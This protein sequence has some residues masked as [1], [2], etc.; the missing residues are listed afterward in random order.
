MGVRS[1]CKVRAFVSEAP[2]GLIAMLFTDL[3]GSTRLAA[4]LGDAWAGVLD[5]HHE[6][7]GDAIRTH[8]GWVEL[9]AGDGFFATFADVRSAALAGVSAQRELAAREW[10]A[11]VGELRVRMGLHV[12]E[13]ERRAHGCVGLEVHRASRV[14]AAAH[15]GQLLM[16][17]A[18]ADLV[19]DVVP[20]QPLGAHRLKDFPAPIALFSAV[21]DGRGAAA[22][23]PPRTLDVRPGRVPAAPARL[24][25]READLAR[26]RAALLNEGE[27][28]ITLLGR[29]G[30]GKTSLA[31]IAAN[32]LLDD[33]EGGV[34]WIDATQAG[35]VAGVCAAIARE[36]RVTSQEAGANSLIA[37]LASREPML[38]VL[39][40]VER[41]DGA[42]QLLDRLVEEIPDLA[43]LA[44]SQLPLRCRYERR[45]QLDCLDIS[46]AMALLHRTAER[47]DIPLADDD[48]A[49]IELVTLLDGL[50]LAIELA[51][52]RLRLFAPA[53]LLRRLHESPGILQDRTRPDRHRSLTAALDWTLALLDDDARALFERLGAFAGPVE[54][55]EIEAVAGGTGTDAIAGLEALLEPAL[56][57][58]IETGD[59][60]VRFGF[61]EVVRQEASRRLDAGGGDTWRRAHAERQ[62]DVVWPLRVYEIVDSPLVETGKRAAPETM[63]AL[64]WAWDHDRRLAREIALGRYPLAVHSGALQEARGLIDRLASD[65]GED[66]GVVDLLRVHRLSRRGDPAGDDDTVDG[67]VTLFDE[68]GDPHARFLCAFNLSITL[69]RD[70]RYDD[71]LTWNDSAS[72]EVKRFGA[73]AAACALAQ[74][75]D[76]LL[77][78]GR[79]AEADEAIDAAEAVA[80]ER[81]SPALERIDILRAELASRRGAHAEAFDAYSRFLT[82]AELADDQ[83]YIEITIELLV[84]ALA[85]AGRERAMLEMAGIAEA[86]AH[87]RAAQ[88]ADLPLFDEP[89]PLVAAALR[90]LGPEGDALLSAGR[91]TAPV[92]RV[93]RAYALIYDNQPADDG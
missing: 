43:L 80:G 46:G 44:T 8:G 78:A 38:L 30:V 81:R 31:L 25:G 59:G 92:A 2:S 58:R 69:T 12:G 17:A 83:G 74:R 35:D 39:D 14:G 49:C 71:A 5:A 82:N 18:A 34:W 53:D 66:P 7:V 21:I 42:G 1:A 33:F 56:V 63:A 86:L 57:R 68:I 16:T 67:Y 61:P 47:L 9:V 87:D 28:L 26:V 45:L 36:C 51:A 91:F 60:R 70:R 24:I 55:T 50:P 10:P 65:P 73:L 54:L 76:L 11:S 19:R 64:D 4:S 23:P 52:A 75:A 27:R 90:Q 15:G 22:F 32:D 13:V 40:N 48:P 79:Y 85:R 29:G 62:R 84:R 3:E 72:A 37:D 41:I 6:L 93:K 77:E 20:S 88:G 89:E